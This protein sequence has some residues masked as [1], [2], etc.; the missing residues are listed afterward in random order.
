M[1]AAG[2]GTRVHLQVRVLLAVVTK[3]ECTPKPLLLIQ[4]HIRTL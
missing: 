2:R 3:G 4:H 1:A